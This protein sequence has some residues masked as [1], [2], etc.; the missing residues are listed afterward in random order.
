VLYA[1]GGA[2]GGLT[3]FMDEGRL[4]YVYNMM[5]IERYQA[6]S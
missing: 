4:V 3:L 6:R 2:F 5:I 1:L